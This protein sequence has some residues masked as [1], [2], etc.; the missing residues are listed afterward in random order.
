[1]KPFTYLLFLSLVIF[2]CSNM[3][4]N[5]NQQIKITNNHSSTIMVD[6]WDLNSSN[7]VDPSPAVSVEKVPFLQIDPSES[8]IV[9][10]DDIQG[11]KESE[12]IRLFLYEVSGD[13]AF[14]QTSFSFNSRKISIH[15]GID[16]Y[17][18]N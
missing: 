4:S 3:N 17:Y 13:S 6:L 5:S 7:T 12:F 11:E 8:I 16:G 10:K 1:M 14:Y 18:L 9:N 2:G 15:N